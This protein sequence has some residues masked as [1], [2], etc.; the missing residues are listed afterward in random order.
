MQDNQQILNQFREK[1][2]VVC[3]SQF[4]MSNFAI[5]S[6]LKFVASQAPLME[7]IAKCNQG[8]NYK[9]LFDESCKKNI[10]KMPKSQKRIV[11]LVTGILFDIDR[12]EIDL[13]IFLNRFFDNG[14]TERNYINFCR[15]IIIP[16]CNAFDNL[17]KEVEDEV[18]DTSQA[19]NCVVSKC[20]KEQV[21]PMIEDLK[22]QIISD[23]I[24]NEVKRKDYLA[25]LEGLYY[26]FELSSAKMI[27]AMWLG[28]K[29]S[30]IAYKP[31][32]S[33]LLSIQQFMDMYI[34]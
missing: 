10:L 14:E 32:G 19:D 5:N 6:M 7:F 22:E 18:Y 21:L 8:L 31:A 2:N 9:E 4:I 15:T 29:Y 17:G 27:K 24:L 1:C 11:A 30:I 13:N 26:A 12:G 28:I 25:M 16:Y 20:L 33:Y 3:K 34:I 23:P